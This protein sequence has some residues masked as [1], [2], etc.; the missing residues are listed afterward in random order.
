[1]SPPIFQVCATDTTV[2]SLLSQGPT[3]RLYPFGDAPQGDPAP[4]AVWQIVYGSPENYLGNVPDIDSYG[5]QVDV[6]AETASEAREVT[7]A[8]KD[9]VEPLA[10]VV[11]WNGEMRDPVTGLYRVSFTIDW[12]IDR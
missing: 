7:E 3:I 12:F 5:I 1:M 10:H 11:S 9:A 8:I 6:Y 4:Y 2:V